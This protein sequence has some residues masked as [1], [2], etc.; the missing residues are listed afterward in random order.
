MHGAA[1]HR[2]DIA[3]VDDLGPDGRTTA[4]GKSLRQFVGEAG[5]GIAGHHDLAQLAKRI[6]D[7][8]QYRVPTIE[9]VA[10][11]TRPATTLVATAFAGIGR[12]GRVGSAA[13]VVFAGRTGRF[14]SCHGSS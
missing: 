6:G 11:L 10:V 12:R 7:G 3:A 4:L 1:Q 14:V 2:L 13:A 8:G 5:L 9:P